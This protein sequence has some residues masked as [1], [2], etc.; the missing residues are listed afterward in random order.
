M[1]QR[2]A[3][4]LCSARPLKVADLERYLLLMND[5]P[6]VQA[7]G[8]IVPAAVQGGNPDLLIRISRRNH[9]AAVGMSNRESKTLGTWRTD[10]EGDLYGAFG[11]DGRQWIRYRHT[12]GAGLKLAAVGR[13]CVKTSLLL[14]LAQG[15]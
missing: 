7:Q 15:V 4:K 2:Y 1:L 5:V 3:D 14:K 10:V 11:M 8:I 9:D 12:A 13:G 6:G